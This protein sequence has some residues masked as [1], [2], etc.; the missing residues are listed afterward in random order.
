[1]ETNV[2]FDSMYAV[3]A[4]ETGVVVLYTTA[5]LASSFVFQIIEVVFAVVE[6]AIIPL[7][8]GATVSGV[9]VDILSSS[10]LLC[11]T[12]TNRVAM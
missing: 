6:V 4:D 1:M 8:T 3:N 5:P 2:A 12:K 7:M 11:T 10:S 9:V